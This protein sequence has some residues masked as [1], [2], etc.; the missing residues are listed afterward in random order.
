MRELRDLGLSIE[1]RRVAGENQ[2]MLTN[3]E[4]DV[5]LGAAIQLTQNIKAS[6][7]DS[8]GQSRLI[9]AAGL[10]LA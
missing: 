5:D 9:L 6:C 3:Q 8:A 2:Y 10:P 1:A 7:L 4:P